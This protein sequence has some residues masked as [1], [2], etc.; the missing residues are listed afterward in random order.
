[1][2]SWDPCKESIGYTWRDHAIY[3]KRAWYIDKES[4][5]ST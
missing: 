1:M 3:I 4:M 5:K 2:R